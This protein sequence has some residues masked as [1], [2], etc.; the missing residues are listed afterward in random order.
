MKQIKS[1]IFK[2][3]TKFVMSEETTDSVVGPG[4]TGFVSHVKG[5]D[6][7]YTNVVYFEAVIIKRGKSG[8]ERLDVIE[9]STPIFDIDN[10]ELR[11]SMPEERRKYYT[12]IDQVQNK[13]NLL[14]VDKIEFMGWVLAYSRYV[15][16]LSTKTNQIEAWPQDP[17]DIM[18]IMV[19][20]NN[21]YDDSPNSVLENYAHKNIRGPII[22]NIRKR[23]ALLVKCSLSYLFK[24]ANIEYQALNYIISLGIKIDGYEE[25][26]EV[27]KRQGRIMAILRFLDSNNR[28]KI[29]TEQLNLIENTLSWA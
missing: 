7:D 26:S 1:S 29:G 3:G 10:E 24:L 9:L 15:H 27:L 22:L 28:K 11:K 23:E 21:Y 6:H 14:N 20:L 17:N 19:H 25:I 4:T 16:K 12:H 8:K 18:N 2:P 13:T 5:V